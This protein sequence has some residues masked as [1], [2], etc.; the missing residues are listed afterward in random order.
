M[1][2]D[3][4]LSGNGLAP[5]RGK[6]KYLIESGAVRVDGRTVY[7]PAF[8]ITGG[9]V[10]VSEA[11]E[12][13][14][15][16]RG[17]LKLEAALDAFGIDVSGLRAVD[18]GASTGGFTDCLLSRGVREV[19]AV[20]SGREQL[21][22]RLRSDGRVVSLESFNARTLTE[23]DIGGLCDIAVMDV[24]FI[25]QTLLYPAVCRVLSDGGLFISLIKP[26]F[27][28]GRAAVGKNGVVK[29][30]RAR[31]ESVER[32]VAAAAELGLA[33]IGVIDSPIAGGDG[34]RE[35]LAAFRLSA[36]DQK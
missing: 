34:N 21:S 19:C 33:N 24:S 35:Y 10:E 32:C 16:S 31:R 18:I 17:G 23:G 5:S 6:A 14:Y 12:L 4:Y 22:P 3:L 20:D 11:P 30:E 36:A 2:L 25:S 1:R 29:D 28:A 15:V 7:K 26:Q 8:E 27:E 13:R 9:N